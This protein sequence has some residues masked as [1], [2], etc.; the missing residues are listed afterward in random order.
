MRTAVLNRMLGWRTKVAIQ[1]AIGVL[2]GSTPFRI[3][4]WLTRVVRSIPLE[5][6]DLTQRFEKGIDNLH[7]V[8][9]KSGCAVEGKTILE[10]GTGWLGVDLL[11]FYLL[12]AKKIYTVDHHPHLTY[13][14]FK[15]LLSWINTRPDVIGQLEKSELC[16]ASL[17]QQHLAQ[18]R[19]VHAQCSNLQ[20]MLQSMHIEYRISHSCRT[21]P[22]DLPSQGI[23][24][25]YSESVLQRIP[26]EDLR[27][28]IPD[29][30]TR[31]MSPAAVFFHRINPLDVNAH[32]D[33]RLWYL[34]YLRYSDFFFRVFYSG[35]LNTQNRL[36]ESDFV[37]LFTNAGLE[38]MYVGS[39]IL[40]EDLE[41]LQKFPV[42]RRFTSKTIED[43]ATWRSKIVGHKAREPLSRSREHEVFYTAGYTALD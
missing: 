22:L 42:D 24:L 11:L 39:Y 13:A 12:G 4:E 32:L 17:L 35:K 14:T 20:Q 7:F 36:R 30:A 26:E 8:R 34:N 2:P 38:V 5:R 23:D 37:D 29:V 10:L 28:T 1:N 6:T 43:L 19:E 9:L 33:R 31:L 15:N 40:R 41:R 3:N 18:V 16:P 25:F 27:D 21:K